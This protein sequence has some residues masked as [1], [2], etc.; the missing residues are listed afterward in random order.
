MERKSSGRV[1]PAAIP[2]STSGTKYTA[3]SAILRLYLKLQKNQLHQSLRMTRINLKK[4]LKASA[5]NCLSAAVVR[6]SQECLTC[7]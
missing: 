2:F 6:R 5:G 7:V 1:Y 3:A 4:P